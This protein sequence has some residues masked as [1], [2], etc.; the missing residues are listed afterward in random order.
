MTNWFPK[1]GRGVIFGFWSSCVNLGNIVGTLICTFC[2]EVVDFNWEWTWIT[3]NMFILL[4][5]L[6]NL[7]FLVS[8]PEFV[9]LRIE[10]DF[11]EDDKKVTIVN[12]SNEESI[13][14]DAPEKPYGV[15]NTAEK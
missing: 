12:Y 4:M 9:G 10:E 13:I 14:A 6:L 1:K 11:D 5:G 2:K 7:M 8:K 3:L 15:T